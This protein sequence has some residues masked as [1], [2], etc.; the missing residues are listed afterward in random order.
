MKCNESER[1]S[2]LASEIFS[3]FAHILVCQRTQNTKAMKIIN[4]D[5]DD[6]EQ[7]EHNDYISSSSSLVNFRHLQTWASAPTSAF[8][9]KGALAGFSSSHAHFS[10]CHSHGDGAHTIERECKLHSLSIPSTLRPNLLARSFQIEWGR[11]RDLTTSRIN[12]L[13]VGVRS[14]ARLPK[15]DLTAIVQ[16]THTHTSPFITA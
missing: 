13:L 11:A 1:A 2:Y 9:Q 3:S 5:D 4:S 15:F 12:Y 6:D 16:C 10:A 14:L 7:L 8:H